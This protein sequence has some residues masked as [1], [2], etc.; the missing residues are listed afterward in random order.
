MPNIKSSSPVNHQKELQAPKHQSTKK[1]T[2]ASQ[3]I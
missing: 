3:E 2:A 1:V